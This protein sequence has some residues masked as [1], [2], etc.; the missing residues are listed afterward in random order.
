M[1]IYIKGDDEVSINNFILTQKKT[2]SKDNI[3]DLGSSFEQSQVEGLINSDSLFAD[4]KMVIIQPK[5]KD[6][7]DFSEDFLKSLADSKTS[8]LIIIPKSMSANLGVLKTIGKHSQIKA[9]ETPR[10]YT[11]FNF[12]DALLGEKDKHRAIQILNTVEDLD[13]SAI[14]YIKNKVSKY[15]LTIQEAQSF[16]TK[17][18]ALDIAFKTTSKDKKAQLLDLIIYSDK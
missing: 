10:D 16:Y 4:T 3:F 1:L 9:F 8:T 17:L 11:F 13:E 14:P 12:C 7:I 6:Q 2:I 15:K 5:R 18:L